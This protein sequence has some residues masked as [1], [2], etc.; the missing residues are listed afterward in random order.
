MAEIIDKGHLV[1]LQA[2]ESDARLQKLEL[3]LQKSQ[4]SMAAMLT[5]TTLLSMANDL[6]F[7]HACGYQMFK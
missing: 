6:A 1:H 5:E 2:R 7:Y 4:A 3:E